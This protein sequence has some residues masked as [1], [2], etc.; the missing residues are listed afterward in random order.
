MKQSLHVIYLVE[1]H[2]WSWYSFYLW[3][4]GD[5]EGL[6]N[7]LRVTHIMKEGIYSQSSFLP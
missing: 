2:I 5:L 3:V 6:N 7:I 1:K 4:N